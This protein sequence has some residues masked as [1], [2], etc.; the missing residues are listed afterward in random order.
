RTTA[1]YASLFRPTLLVE[2][3]SEAGSLA[4][5]F[6]LLMLVIVAA[7]NIAVRLTRAARIRQ[8]QIILNWPAQV[9]AA[10]LPLRYSLAL[11]PACLILRPF[12][13]VG[14]D[15]RARLG[16]SGLALARPYHSIE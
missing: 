11:T 10:I 12:G 14:L 13:D 7:W 1:E 4:V 2:R 15:D 3:F 9:G 16:G 6:A 5:F 8:R